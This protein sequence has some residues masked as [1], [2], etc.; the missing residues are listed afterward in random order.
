M[1]LSGSLWWP[2]VPLQLL[3]HQGRWLLGKA[4]SNGLDKLTSA[5]SL[6]L[7]LLGGGLLEATFVVGV[8][9]DYV[10]LDSKSSGVGR[11]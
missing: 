2:T 5:E 10:L 1:R 7:M 3:G 11:M 8:V 9:M 6:K 4:L